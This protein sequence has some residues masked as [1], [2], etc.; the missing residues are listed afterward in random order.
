MA[1]TKLPK[2]PVKKKKGGVKKARPSGKPPSRSVL[3]REDHP[4]ADALPGDDDWKYPGSGS[5]G[6]E[7]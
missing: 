4:T 1:K 3:V 7:D 2:R 5:G 6:S